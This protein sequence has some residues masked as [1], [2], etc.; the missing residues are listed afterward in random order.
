VPGSGRATLL[1]YR[2]VYRNS[3]RSGGKRAGDD[4]IAISC[5]GRRLRAVPRP[6]PCWTWW[7]WLSAGRS[8]ITGGLWYA[9]GYGPWYVQRGVAVPLTTMAPSRRWCCLISSYALPIP[10]R[11]WGNPLAHSMWSPS[12]P[13]WFGFPIYP[14]IGG[15]CVVGMRSFWDD[16]WDS[17]AHGGHRSP[18]QGRLAC[19]CG[20]YHDVTTRVQESGIT[21]ADPL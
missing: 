6:S 4:P 12:H 1:D 2:D 16:D 10:R 7:R 15:V 18:R 11:G 5:T 17:F 13:G 3:W 9:G 20:V 19:P 14:E 8:Q 21:V